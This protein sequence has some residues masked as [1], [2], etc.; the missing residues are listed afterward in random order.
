MVMDFSGCSDSPA[1]IATI[2]VPI[3]ENI[4]TAIPIKTELIPVGKNPP[5]PRRLETPGDAIPW[6]IP[7]ITD[8]AQE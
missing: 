3:K 6:N 1:A 5:F 4:T 7:Q 2:S 8:I